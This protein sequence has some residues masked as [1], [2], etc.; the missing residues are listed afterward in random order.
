MV[1][2]SVSQE[3]TWT[4]HQTDA[5][6]GAS[7]PLKPIVIGQPI[8]PQKNKQPPPYPYKP[9]NHP[10]RGNLDNLH[11]HLYILQYRAMMA[12]WKIAM[13]T[14]E[15]DYRNLHGHFR[16]Q[17]RDWRQSAQKVCPRFKR[18]KANPKEGEDEEEWFTFVQNV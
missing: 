18:K 5:D 4:N 15:K 16:S 6:A 8:P 9:D 14:L 17:Y 3:S 7:R 10:E 13:E 1:S 11:S 2:D 12:P